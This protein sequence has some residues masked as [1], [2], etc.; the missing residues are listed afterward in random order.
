MF[1]E[2][3]PNMVSIISSN[4]IYGFLGG[5][6]AEAGLAYLGFENISSNSWGIMLFWAQ[7]G[8]GIMAGSWW[9]FV[10][11]GLAI[12]I[13]G[14]SLTLMNFAIDQITNPRLKVRK[15]MAKGSVQGVQ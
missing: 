15:K 4:L 13:V 12:A 8:G 1:A 14:T 5:I 2:I 10:P 3:L 7:N 6:M 9:W 11:P